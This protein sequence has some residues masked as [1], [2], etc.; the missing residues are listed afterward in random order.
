MREDVLKKQ[1]AKICFEV[2]N[3]LNSHLDEESQAEI[4]AD[5]KT[6]ELILNK[7]FSNNHSIIQSNHAVIEILSCRTPS[8]SEK[9]LNRILTNEY[10]IVLFTNLLN[11]H[12]LALFQFFLIR[13]ADVS[14]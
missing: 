2:F 14:V 13:Y 3:R 12:E 5:L 8:Q 10:H 7:Y 6:Q 1:V 11:Y 4:I 9:L